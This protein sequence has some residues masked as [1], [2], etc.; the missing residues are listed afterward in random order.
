MDNLL[1]YIARLFQ[2]NDMC[3]VTV[4]ASLYHVFVLCETSEVRIRTGVG[5]CRKDG[6]RV[7]NGEHLVF[8]L[9]AYSTSNG[10]GAKIRNGSPLENTI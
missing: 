8:L 10:A 1:A 2:R 6:L 9:A 4:T 5:V 3:L 7:W